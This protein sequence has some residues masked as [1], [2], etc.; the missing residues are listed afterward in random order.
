[1]FFFPC[2]KKTKG[3]AVILKFSLWK[4]THPVL[5]HRLLG[6][7]QWSAV[8][9][10]WSF[11]LW[12]VRL[13]LTSNLPV[14]L[15]FIQLVSS[16]VLQMLPLM[17][18][19]RDCWEEIIAGLY[20]LVLGFRFGIE[21]VNCS[22]LSRNSFCML[23]ALFPSLQLSRECRAEVQRILH[24]RAMDVKLDPALQDKCMIDLGKWCSEKT[25]TGQVLHTVTLLLV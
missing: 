5:L 18:C 9:N 15:D 21:D 12:P 22:D 11:Q 7:L 20:C 1:M 25:E 16:T 4:Q 10:V 24:Q 14:S 3:A 13:G 2:G 17:C 8:L 6:D 19:S 23:K